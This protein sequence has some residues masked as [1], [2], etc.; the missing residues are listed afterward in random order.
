MWSGSSKKMGTDNVETIIGRNTE[1]SGNVVFRGGLY[2][3]GKVNGNI[4]A[5]EDSESLLVLNPEGVIEGEVR[6]P[7]MVING[8]VDGDVHT[9][10]K[11]VLNNQARIDGD[12]Y[13]NLLEMEMGAAINGNL[14]HQNK[15]EKR[16]LEYQN[17]SEDADASK[18]AA[19]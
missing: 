3:D 18:A 17:K 8:Q 7:N 5:E 15:K 10:D 11:V 12:V 13:Y 9:T 4:Q 14:V 16:L 2:I 1:I 6:V 19:K